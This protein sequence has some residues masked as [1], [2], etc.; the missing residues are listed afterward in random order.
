VTLEDLI[1][2]LMGMEIMDETDDVEDM[3]T[4]ARKQW[5]ERARTMGLE[6]DVFDQRKAEYVKSSDPKSVATD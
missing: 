3:R 1:E 6:V 4:L 2:T 5:V